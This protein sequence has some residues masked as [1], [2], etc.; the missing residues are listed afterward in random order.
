MSCDTRCSFLFLWQE[1]NFL[2]QEIN[3]LSQEI[4][5]PWQEINF[6]WQEINFLWHEINFLWKE[7]NFLSQE[8]FFLWQR[9]VFLWIL[10]CL[11]GVSHFRDKCAGFTIKISCETLRFR[12]N[13]V[14]RFPVI[15]PPWGRDDSYGGD[16]L[17]GCFVFLLPNLRQSKSEYKSITNYCFESSLSFWIEMSLP[18]ITTYLDF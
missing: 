3:V 17:F 15:I 2:W 1:I 12:G 11:L 5:L 10:G 14:P 4:N 7:I 9:I 18:K 16:P 13:L 6:L 8:W